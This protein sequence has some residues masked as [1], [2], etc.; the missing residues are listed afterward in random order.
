M[1]EE[2]VF[3]SSVEAVPLRLEG[4]IHIP[5]GGTAPRPAVVLCHP[6]SLYGG[7]AEVPVILKTAQELARRG[8]MALRFNFRGVGRS[9]GSFGDGVAEVADVAGA[10][11]Y[12]E[13][14]SEVDPERVYLMGYSFGAS[15]GLRHVEA[16]PRIRGVVALCLPLGGLSIGS[17]SEEF[18]Q[19]YTRPKL[20]LAG[21]RDHVCPLSELRP[22]VESLP[23]PK[24]LVVLEGVDHF[25]WGREQEAANH[26]AG[27]LEGLAGSGVGE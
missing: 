16:D 9:E 11:D 21:D 18:W 22:L 23:E 24:Q 5:S 20:F 12:L 26:I 4:V 17:L 14:R 1:Q 3:F 8:M 15:V 10:V 6:H 27:F 13:A 25:L 19:K 2:R 7:S